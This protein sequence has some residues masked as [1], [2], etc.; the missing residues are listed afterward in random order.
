MS[1]ILDTIGGEGDPQDIVPEI[2]MWTY[3]QVVFAQA[4]ICPRE[5]D[6]QNSL[7]FLDTNRATNFS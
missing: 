4:R 6:A 1:I 7:E 5:W 3:E 2:L